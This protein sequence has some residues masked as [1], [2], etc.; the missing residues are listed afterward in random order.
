MTTTATADLLRPALMLL[1]HHAERPA[2]ADLTGCGRLD[3]AYAAARLVFP[4]VRLDI[5][6]WAPEFAAPALGRGVMVGRWG[7]DDIEPGC[8]VI[9]L[10]EA[11]WQCPE[12]VSASSAEGAFA[13]FAAG[14]IA[15]RLVRDEGLRA[16]MLAEVA[17]GARVALSTVGLD[18]VTVGE[19]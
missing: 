3:D 15:A 1:A 11:V 8:V 18:R 14:I 4:I 5:E 19:V 12:G 2:G 13:G 10:E 17:A 7:R 16:A 9:G 6:L